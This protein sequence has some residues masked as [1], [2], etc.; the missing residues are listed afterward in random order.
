MEFDQENERKYLTIGALYT[1]FIFALVA[2]FNYTMPYN[3]NPVTE[4][5][6]I[7]LL[8]WGLL[9]VPLVFFPLTSDW[10]ITDFGFAFGSHTRIAFFLILLPSLMG[11]QNVNNSWLGGFFEAFARTGEEVFFRGFLFLLLLKIFSRRERPVAWA[12]VISALIFALMHTQTFQP[13]YFEGIEMNRTFLIV[14]RLFNVFLLGLIFAWLRNW[15][16]AILPSAIFHSLIQG[17]MKALP[18]C[19]AIYAGVMYWAH[20]RG[21]KVLIE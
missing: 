11:A 14:Q 7:H 15:T 3:S 10:E 13:S 1:A 4:P 9:Y 19:L 6:S 2:Y 16:N 12:S 18:F 8:L 17:G 5:S 21:E 20:T